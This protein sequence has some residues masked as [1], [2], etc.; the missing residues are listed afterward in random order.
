MHSYGAPH[1]GN[2]SQGNYVHPGN[3]NWSHGQNPQSS[4]SMHHRPG[5]ENGG[6][7]DWDHDFWHHH[8]G[9][10]WGGWWGGWWGWDPFWFSFWGCY[11][12]GWGGCYADYFCPY[13][14]I[15][16]GYPAASYIYP[17]ADDGQYGANFAS[18]PGEP[19]PAPGEPQPAVDNGEAAAN[20]ALQ[21]YNEART[22]FTQGDYHNA[23]RLAGHSAV[24]SP[25]NARVHELTS[26]ALFAS[27]EY[28]GAATEAHAAL[29]LGAPSDWPHLFAYYNDADRY[30]NQLRKLEKT[31]ADVPKSCPGNSCW[32]ITT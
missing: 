26:L 9:H 18:P 32:G 6:H 29:A 8:W 5:G 3:P 14:P 13:G 27:G 23:L 4:Q 16:G 1:S 20:E 21:Y 11:P 7:H 10:G 30:T 12:F 31:V 19:Q 22:A 2:W 24:E 17:Y 25:Q 28:R 15:Y